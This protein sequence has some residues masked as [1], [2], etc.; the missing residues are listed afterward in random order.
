L[1][2]AVEGGV[3]SEINHCQVFPQAHGV[4]VK[5]KITAGTYRRFDEESDVEP[6][7]T[8]KVGHMSTSIRKYGNLPILAQ[9]RLEVKK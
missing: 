6:Q 8:T 7:R 1:L 2:G 3:T 5:V 9:R 4:E